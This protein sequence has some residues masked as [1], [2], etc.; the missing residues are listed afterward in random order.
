MSQKNYFKVLQWGIY[1]SFLTFFL[2][3]NNWLFP[4][5]T[6]KQVFF[7]ILI[8]ILA[9]VWLALIVKYPAIRPKKSWLTWSFLAWL[10]ILLLTCFTGVDFNMSFW[11]DAN[12][13][14]GWFHLAHFFLFYLIVITV[15]RTKADWQRLF[16]FSLVSAVLIVVYSLIKP[17]S[18]VYDKTSSVNVGNNIS[19]LG[20]ATYV[21]GVMLVCF[22]FT[23][24]G[25]LKS[26]LIYQK[27]LYA[28]AGLMILVGFFYADVS[29]SQA[30][31]AVSL[32]LF[33]L[34]YAW[35]AAAPKTRKISLI[36]V[37][38]F[39]AV[40]ATLYG[41]R[42][43]PFMNNRFGKIFRDFSLQNTNLDTRLYAWRAGWKGWLE[44]PIL[45]WGYGNF[46][47][48]ND[49]FFDGS[50]YRY[51][52]GEEY[53]DRAHNNLIDLAVTT[54]TVGLL[55]Y[56]LIFAAIAYYLIKGYRQRKF[57]W[58][59][60]A[61]ATAIV[62]GYFIHNL[63]VFD[64]WGNY[65][66]FWLTLGW[67]F[68]LYQGQ[69]PA[70]EG[71][72]KVSI[73]AV[74][75]EIV[76]WLVAGAGALSLIFY[77]N[78]AFAKVFS[79]TINFVAILNS[80]TTSQEILDYYQRPFEANTPMDRSGINSL[81]DFFADHPEALSKLSKEEKKQVFDFYINLNKKVIALNPANSLS[82]L[83]LGR[84][85]M[86]SCMG[87]ADKQYCQ[88]ALDPL[89][90]SMATGGQHISTYLVKAIVQ[91]YLNDVDGS[92]ATLNQALKFYDGY[93]DAHCQL[94]Q[95]YLVVKKDNVAGREH[96]KQCVAGGGGK[97]F[98]ADPKMSEEVKN[99]EKEIQTEKQQQQQQTQTDQYNNYLTAG[100]KYKAQGDTGNHD[101]YYQ[102]ID[103]FTKAADV[104]GNKVWI[105]YLNIG[106]LYR[107][108]GEYGKA[109]ENYKKAL[110]I[111]GGDSTIF[112]AEIELYQVYEKRPPAEVKELYQ[113]AL[114]VVVV[115]NVNIMI[116]YAAFCRD[117]G[118][119]E[120][121]IN[122][123]TSLLKSYPDNQLYQQEIDKLKAG[124][125]K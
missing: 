113:A 50:Y 36:S 97:L 110:T 28:L 59:E 107:S 109:D 60:L 124:L 18:E 64:S 5:T 62:V 2:V 63:A 108:L 86:T 125:K 38:V 81:S 66:L 74:N 35:L 104:S 8:E 70:P 30:G 98:D 105:P 11:G 101:A 91:L 77:Y 15:F 46:Y 54:G 84:T 72:A 7:N 120:D 88:A 25:W 4:Y 45:G 115:D 1:A 51:T 12:R 76:V 68:S 53:F 40:I 29:G 10:A 69:E 111:S 42:Q 34:L 61:I 43:Q 96:L 75:R 90:K 24:Y 83:R 102:A 55:I 58:Q 65:F 13:M 23:L 56:L 99:T 123:Y 116:N 78:V 6:L 39:I 32:V 71:P 89:A 106:N 80:A 103:A 21:A 41:L 44:K 49:K 114:K 16:N 94:A 9:V 17:P 57:G 92:I 87:L 79:R 14:L 118:Y 82:Q 37:G 100:L 73:K 47:A 3:E 85:L 52:M 31:L 93:T 121:A 122:A 67:I 26:K 27:I 119:T 19:T 22:Y 112:L 20:N 48:V 117:N 95:I 33:G